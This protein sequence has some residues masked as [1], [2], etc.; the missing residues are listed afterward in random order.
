MR[1][2]GSTFK[3]FDYAAAFDTDT[4][5]LRDG[6][7]DKAIPYP[8]DPEHRVVTNEFGETSGK[9]MN[10]KD[11]IRLSKNTIAIQV[12]QVV[13][14]STINQYAH[15]MGVTTELSPY[16]PTAIGATAIHPIDLCSAYSIIPNHGNRCLPMGVVRVTTADGESVDPANFL[17]QV[18]ENLL[19][20]STVSQLDEA[21]LSVC[22]SG[23]GVPARGTQQTGVVENAHG[24]TGTTDEFRDVWFAGY[25]PELTTVV[26]VGSVS[27]DRHGHPV[28]N[29]MHGA[30]GGHTCGQIWHDFMVEAVPIQRQFQAANPD[31]SNAPAT[32]SDSAAPAVPAK[33]ARRVVP[34]NKRPTQPGDDS[35]L[36]DQPSPDPTTAAPGGPGSAGDTRPQNPVPPSDGGSPDRPNGQSGA[37]ATG[38][39]PTAGLRSNPPEPTPTTAQTNRQQDDELI[40]VKVCAESGDLV[41]GN[42]CPEYIVKKVSRT[43]ALHM[44]RCRLHHAPP[45]EKE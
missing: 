10:M 6:F 45:G 23:T 31:L 21:F 44:H 4:F 15:K 37:P 26:W 9:W 3:L 11:A 7:V 41:N 36:I 5:S 29:S 22:T 39:P 25:T 27:K 19:K 42:W 20:P 18:Q 12:A 17:P 32:A 43:V 14:M 40:S 13:G 38:A 24:K 34:T 2:P 30:T 35:G 1:Q 33:R 28:Y 8:G 16:L